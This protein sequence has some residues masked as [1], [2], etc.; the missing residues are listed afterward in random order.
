M[1]RQVIKNSIAVIA[2]FLLSP[3]LNINLLIPLFLTTIF[4]Y[5]DV[6]KR[7]NPSD[8]R[9]LHLCLLFLIIFT[10][11]NLISREALSIYYIPFAL[12]PMLVIILW[13]DLMISLLML[14]A[15]S[16]TFAIDFNSLGLGIIF[17]VSAVISTVLLINVRRRSQIIRAGFIV[18]LFQ[19]FTWLFIQN[20]RL[21]DDPDPYMFLFINGVACGIAVVGFLPVFEYI[22]G[23]VTNI[24]LL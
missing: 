1:K 16:L 10:I 9:F 7:Q 17:F 21:L 3:V 5:L 23:Q 12:I 24:S 4:I 18:G 2:L 8:C 22:F 20:F 15:C 19:V 14:L 11:G 6:S 13:Q